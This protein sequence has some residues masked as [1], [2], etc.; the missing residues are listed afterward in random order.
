M[1]SCTPVLD[2]AVIPPTHELFPKIPLFYRP[3]FPKKGPLK[4]LSVTARCGVEVLYPDFATIAFWTA[5]ATKAPLPVCRTLEW[6]SNP[7]R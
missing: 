6:I 7:V 3:T 1:N 4:I 5:A 2:H